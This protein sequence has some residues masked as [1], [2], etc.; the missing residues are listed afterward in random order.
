MS[1]SSS[2]TVPTLRELP[3]TLPRE[4]SIEI[5]LEEGVLIFRASKSVQER[6]EAL[7]QK[8]RTSS[9]SPADARE[10]RQYEEVDDYLSYLNR[11]TRNLARS[12][13]AQE[14]AGAS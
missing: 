11:L 3:A 14:E 13:Q 6:I 1:I 9:L 7:L 5:E 4:G 10:L 12:Q 8:E 2:Q